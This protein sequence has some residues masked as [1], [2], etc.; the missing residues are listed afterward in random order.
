MELPTC[1]ICLRIYTFGAA[2]NYADP[3]LEYRVDPHWELTDPRPNFK[4]VNL[5]LKVCYISGYT[6]TVA[7]F[8]QLLIQ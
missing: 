8:E 7:K 4:T 5:L 1:F 3:H 2:T 6:G